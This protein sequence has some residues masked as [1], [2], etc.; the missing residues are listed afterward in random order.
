MANPLFSIEQPIAQRVRSQDCSAIRE[1]VKL[2][3]PRR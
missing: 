3:A 1:I 2:S